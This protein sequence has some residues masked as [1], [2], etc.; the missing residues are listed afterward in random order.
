MEESVLGQGHTN[1]CSPISKWSPSCGARRI[2]WG[3]EPVGH[4]GKIE[5]VLA[6]KLSLRQIP[7]AAELALHEGTLIIPSRS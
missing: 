7:A 2:E 4:L 1:G 6:E 5:R 3:G